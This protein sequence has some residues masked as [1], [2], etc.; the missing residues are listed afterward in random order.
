[1]PKP[2]VGRIVHFVLPHASEYDYAK[3]ERV[4]PHRPALIVRVWD[5]VHVNLQAFTDETNDAPNEGGWYTSVHY[6]E[7]HEPHSWHWP[8][9][10][11]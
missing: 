6:S 8:E 3:N 2:S 4:H 10:V 9:T 11:E 5:D 7:A 1:M